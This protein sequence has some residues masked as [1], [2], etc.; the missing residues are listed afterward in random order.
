MLTFYPEFEAESPSEVEV[1][2]LFDL[3]C[4][5]KVSS[6]V[7]VFCRCLMLSCWGR[8]RGW[9][10]GYFH[11]SVTQICVAEWSSLFHPPQDAMH[12]PFA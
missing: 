10:G 5:M 11:M 2:F 4:S 1:V 12:R 7:V 9:V 6:S 8:G 3:S